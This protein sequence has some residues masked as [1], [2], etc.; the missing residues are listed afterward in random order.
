MLQADQIRTIQSLLKGRIEKLEGLL[1]QENPECFNHQRHLEEGSP[2]RT[3]WHYG[4]LCAL[5]DVLNAI[6]KGST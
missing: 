6:E 2:E 5:R 3:Y 1:M 4:Y